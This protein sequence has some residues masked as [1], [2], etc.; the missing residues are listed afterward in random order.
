MIIK[1]GVWV[2]NDDNTVMNKSIQGGTVPALIW[3]DVMKVATEPYGKADFNY[4]KVDLIPFGSVKGSKVIGEEEKEAQEQEKQEE[5]ELN[6][7]PE[8]PELPE[9]IRKIEQSK[10]VTV[11]S[12]PVQ[13]TQPA[14]APAPAAAPAVRP[15][16]AA[17]PA[18]APIPLAAP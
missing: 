9:S 4:P 1:I 15:A 14:Q 6:T 10:P 18:A 16:Q 7:Q 5:I 17:K 12:Q 3:K 2:G 11:Q 13:H 8:Q